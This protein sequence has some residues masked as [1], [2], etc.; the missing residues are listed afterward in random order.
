MFEFGAH[1]CSESL[2]FSYRIL[3]YGTEYLWCPLMSLMLLVELKLCSFLRIEV[4][5]KCLSVSCSVKRS[6][7]LCWVFDYWSLLVE[8]NVLFVARNHWF[9]LWLACWSNVLCWRQLLLRSFLENGARIHRF[10]IVTL[11]HPVIA[12]VYWASFT[13]SLRSLLDYSCL[14]L[15]RLFFIHTIAD[16]ETA[17]SWFTIVIRQ[18]IG[19]FLDVIVDR[20]FF[21]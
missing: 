20:N 5:A 2:Q 7:V 8:V 14:Y 13:V 4:H 9:S 21:F 6:M 11:S 15:A 3:L 19:F 10:D 17:F 1:R 12:E 18:D 16:V